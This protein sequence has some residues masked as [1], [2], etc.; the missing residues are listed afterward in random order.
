D[1]KSNDCDGNG[2][3]DECQPDCDDDGTPD[4]CELPPLGSSADCNA[5][6][7]PDECDIADGTSNDCDDNGVPD[8][9]QLD[10]DNDGTPDICELPPLG[11]SADCNGNLIPDE[12]DIDDGTSNDCD[13]NGVPD[14]CQLDC[15]DDGT[16]DICE[17]PPVG[18]SPDCNDNLIP[19][20]CD[21]DDGTSRDSDGNGVPDECEHA[22][23][24]HP[25][26]PHDA[27]K[28]RYVSFDP[29]YVAAS[30]AFK[31]KMT[32]GPEV[33]AV[34]RWVGQPNADSVSRVVPDPFF[35]DAWPTVVHVGD[36][37]IVPVATYEIRATMDGVAF[38]APLEVG[39]IHKPGNRYYG[40]VVG[41]G[42]GDLPPLPG[43][44]PPNG[45]VN[46]SDV[47]AY[48]LTV[49]SSSTPSVHTTWVDMHGLGE[50]SP[51]NFILNVSDLQ[52][53]LFG[54]AGQRYTDTPN[55]LDPAD[56][57]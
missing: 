52:R 4:I 13:D 17:L 33:S 47:Q 44:T 42:T 21:I 39:T 18:S 12:C 37:Y 54:L 11:S 1:G 30:I 35:D 56:C 22:P 48:L 2:V 8:E 10:C 23:P 6:L 24:L 28:N 36:C 14:E 7:I 19:D 50:G 9:C 57:P 32:T 15:D 49:H 27:R 3:P 26:P 46:V 20:E 29:N 31:I 16:P 41:F 34:R 55:Q 5:N 51:P 45:V 53:I 25:A 40:D 38:T 43:F